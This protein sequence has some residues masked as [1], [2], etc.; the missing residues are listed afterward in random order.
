[1]TIYRVSLSARSTS[2]CSTN[3]SGH[4]ETLRRWRQGRATRRSPHRGTT[5]AQDTRGPRQDTA[6]RLAVRTRWANRAKKP[7]L[8][9]LISKPRRVPDRPVSNEPY[10]SLS[11]GPHAIHPVRP[12]MPLAEFSKNTEC[13]YFFLSPLDVTTVNKNPLQKVS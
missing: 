8:Q 10:L 5:H 3:H 2:S 1:M 12:A 4:N 11:F 13:N 6:E 7:E 9:L